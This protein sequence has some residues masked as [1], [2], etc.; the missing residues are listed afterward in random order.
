MSATRPQV[1]S[2][3]RQALRE[4]GD[5]I[6]FAGPRPVT[7]DEFT[8]R[9]DAVSS[10]LRDL[11]VDVGDRVAIWMDK[12]PRYAEAIVAALQV[13]CAY[14]PL[15]GGQP[16]GR[17]LTILEDAEPVALFT[18][19]RHL[20][21]L[22]L[23]DLPASLRVV[24]VDGGV[25]EAVEDPVPVRAW[26]EF[27]RVA[28]PGR[29]TFMPAL[30][31]RDLAA[32][33]YTSGSTGKPKGVRIS[34]GGL[35]NFI[36]WV[37]EELDIGPDDVLANH[38][39]FNFDLSTLDLF[40]ALTAGATVWVIGDE[41]AKDVTALAEGVL[42]YGVTVWYSVPSVLN[43]LTV[44][45]ALTAEHAA[46][47][48][49]VLF[50]GE[51]FP[52]PQLR[53]LAERLPAGASLYN[54]YGPTETNVCTYRRVTERDL[55]RDAPV[56]IGGPIT[57]ARLTVVDDDGREVTEPGR[58][59]EL[60]VGG[61]CVTPG[62]W[63]RTEQPASDF[64]CEGRHPTG[65]LVSYE[66]DGALVYRGRKDRMVKISGYRVE[67]G[68]IEAAVLRHPDIADAAVL[69]SEPAGGPARLT[70]YYTPWPGA[71]APTLLQIKQHCARH[72]PKYMLPHR[73]TCLERLPHNANGKIDYRRLADV[74]RTSK[75]ASTGLPV[76]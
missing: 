11:E 72:L 61:D 73:A 66:E 76:T 25:P 53:A 32:I 15:D 5:A 40:A 16:A 18:D 28:T 3:P 65:D 62:Y 63:R 44:S 21:Q 51:V 9:V 6:A 50:A 42:A 37:R 43:L 33:L 36:G 35:A 24:V 41:Q 59:G 48:R 13:G 1:I 55:E 75:A 69:L 68:E 70:L 34:H 27:T 26:E 2:L 60:I 46:S 12:S 49:H 52:V 67:L 39:S 54:L 38:A 8:A 22:P 71:Q 4:R 57:G 14:V 58:I 7:Y 19:E 20:A 47:L 74:P 10:R 23:G 45:G 30:G 17:A 29:V 56:P 64:H 31:P